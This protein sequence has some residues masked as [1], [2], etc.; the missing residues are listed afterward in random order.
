MQRVL[1]VTTLSTKLSNSFGKN[2]PKQKPKGEGFAWRFHTADFYHCHFDWCVSLH[3]WFGVFVNGSD[4]LGEVMAGMVWSNNF[5]RSCLHIVGRLEAV[6][7]W[8][9]EV[10]L[11]LD[12][13]HKL[14]GTP[15][16]LNSME[17][18]LAWVWGNVWKNC[19][20]F[21]CCRIHK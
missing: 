10:V 19:W 8:D 17:P 18:N 20:F 14:Q 6:E 5:Q 12:P 11:G 3:I 4:F 16:F 9:H 21:F 2:D 7:R 15:V 1:D 13:F